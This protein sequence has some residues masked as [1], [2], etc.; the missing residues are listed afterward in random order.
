[1]KKLLVLGIAIGLGICLTVGLIF[2]AM[3]H[4]SKADSW[5]T[6]S[7][8]KT[9]SVRFSGI[10][11]T[12]SWPFT[13]PAD[14]RNRRVTINVSRDGKAIVDRAEVYDGD[15]YD[16]D[17]KDL[18]PDMEWSTEN[19]LHLW[20]RKDR[21]GEKP[22]NSEILITNRSGESVRYLYLK[23]GA[24]DLYLMFELPADAR[25]SLHTQLDHAEDL[26]G[27]EGEFNDR[28]ITYSSADFSRSPVSQSP[29]RYE[30]L[31]QKNGCSVTGILIK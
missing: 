15:A 23:A 10:A 17:F 16:S 9:Y 11:S 14:L 30:V 24:T 25:L 7:P 27:C 5:S 1:M 8:R 2:A 26:V 28:R 31:I 6:Q 13:Q 4:Q 18:Y 22:H 3:R 12:P 21:H 20:N 29:N 19:G